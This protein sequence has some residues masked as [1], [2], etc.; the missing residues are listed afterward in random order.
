M[1]SEND[2]CIISCIQGPEIDI[3]SYDIQIVKLAGESDCYESISSLYFHLLTAHIYFSILG[4][5]HDIGHG[6]F[7]HMFEHEFLP[8]VLPGS[9]W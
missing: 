9:E 1:S 8:R 5:L 7:S 4:L 3:D 6:P 2:Y